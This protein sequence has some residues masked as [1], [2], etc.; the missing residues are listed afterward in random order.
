MSSALLPQ[1]SESR[2]PFFSIQQSF[3]DKQISKNYCQQELH[4]NRSLNPIYPALVEGIY[5]YA[6][7]L[8]A[9]TIF[10]L[11]FT[12]FYFLLSLFLI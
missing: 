12:I 4:N 3:S 7:I 6:T 10:F 1:H 11:E 9:Y 5:V 8:S 2:K